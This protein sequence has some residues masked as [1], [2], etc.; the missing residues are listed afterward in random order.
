MILSECKILNELAKTLGMEIACRDICPSN[1]PPSI[2]R[3]GK[4]LGCLIAHITLSLIEA[5]RLERRLR[6]VFVHSF[7]SFQNLSTDPW[8]LVL[9][10]ILL[11]D[12]GKLTKQYL[13]LRDFQHNIWS[14]LVTYK[15]LNEPE[16]RIASLAVLLHHEAYH[17]RDLEQATHYHFTFGQTMKLQKVNFDVDQ[18]DVF[19][20]AVIANLTTL[21]LCDL[22]HVLSKVKEAAL[23]L[24]HQDILRLIRDLKIHVLYNPKIYPQALPIHWLLTLVDNRAASARDVYWQ[25][26]L[27]SVRANN[28]CEF[29]QEIDR[30][31]QI[32]K[33]R[34]PKFVFLS[35]LQ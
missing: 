15:V 4:P 23:A 7:H 31:V 22:T 16:R 33:P 29:L 20:K 35:A 14:S 27:K 9:I 24:E 21:N 30:V 10:S 11:H 25:K 1:P 28:P 8:N 5:I 18:L 17:W 12:T 2:K 3:D 6:P 19:I 34:T 32:L 26:V 13:E